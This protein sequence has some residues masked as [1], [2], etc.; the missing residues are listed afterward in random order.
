MIEGLSGKVISILGLVPIF[1]CAVDHPGYQG[2]SV[3]S[4]VDG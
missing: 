2:C 1:Y 4:K 3:V